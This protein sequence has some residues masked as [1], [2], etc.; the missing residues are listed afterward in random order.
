MINIKFL[1]YISLTIIG[2]LTVM[3]PGGNN[4]TMLTLYK[5]L[6]KPQVFN[7]TL[8]IK[9]N[10]LIKL[11]RARP[12]YIYQTSKL[13]ISFLLYLQMIN[14]NNWKTDKARMEHVTQK[15]TWSR[16]AI[17]FILFD[18]PYFSGKRSCRGSLYRITSQY[19][20][21]ISCCCVYT[22]VFAT[23]L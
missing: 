16:P 10:L 5:M 12:M 15:W 20:H 11:N 2:N 9:V 4:I 17:N 19:Y 6:C 7:Q 3:M 22:Y 14:Q 21:C 13:L 1:Y 8:E 23:V 18:L